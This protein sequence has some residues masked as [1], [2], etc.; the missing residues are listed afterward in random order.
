M[1]NILL[2]FRSFVS[3]WSPFFVIKKSLKKKPINP[4]SDSKESMKSTKKRNAKKFIVS[5]L[6]ADFKNLILIHRLKCLKMQLKCLKPKACFQGNEEKVCL[7]EGHILSLRDGLCGFCLRNPSDARKI[8]TIS[9]LW[10][11]IRG[12]DLGEAISVYT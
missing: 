5:S 7:N 6:Y 1:P 4:T 12:S 2:F 10:V 11:S 3:S 9:M 8:P